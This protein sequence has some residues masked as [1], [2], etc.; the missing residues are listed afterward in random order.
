MCARAGHLPPTSQRTPLGRVWYLGEWEDSLQAFLL[1]AH[2]W[3]A[4]FHPLLSSAFAWRLR[5]APL[6]E[7]ANDE[8]L[9]SQE[10]TRETVRPPACALDE[11]LDELEE[12]EIDLDEIDLD[13]I[14]F[15]EADVEELEAIAAATQRAASEMQVV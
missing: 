3:F 1:P 8:L 10:T 14:D 11:L 2:K 5:R 12:D 6:L 9:A 7:M 13:E 15:N 4:P